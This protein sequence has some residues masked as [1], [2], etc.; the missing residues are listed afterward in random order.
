MQIKYFLGTWGMEGP[1]ESSVRA[2][3]AAGF[4]GVETAVP[5][6]PESCGRFN[7][8]LKDLGL[9]LVAQV[10]T[11]G[12]SPQDHARS[13]E[14]QY[15]RATSL[16]PVFV[17]SH[18]GKDYY[19]LSE[20][21]TIYRHVNRL[22]A[23]L[24]VPVIHEVHRGRATFSTR[25]TAALLEAMPE[26][27]LVADFS[28]WCAV[29]ESFLLDQVEDVDLAIAH[30]HHIHARV[31]HPEGPQVND[32]RAP[33]W[34]EAVEVHLGWW[35]KIAAARRASGSEVLTVT[36]EFGPPAYLPTLPFTRMPVANQ[37][38]IN[39]YMRDFLKENLGM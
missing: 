10:Y 25:S 29:H 27:R 21:Q 32:P 8:L 30:S 36:P 22:V 5:Q 23:E 38:E 4:E 14:E 17:N 2:I 3:H 35:K 39:C 16:Q 12:N 24:G 18:T 7:A 13:F 19:S 11:T 6:D 1:L 31:G 15:R 34:S 9:A 33:E 26:T 28:H 20:N 37:F